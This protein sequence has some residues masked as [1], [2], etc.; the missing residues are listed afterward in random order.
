M[1]LPFLSI[2]FEQIIFM[3][4]LLDFLEPVDLGE[5]NEDNAYTDGQLAKQVT[6]Y[7]GELPSTDTADIVFVGIQE[8]R[9]SGDPD[10]CIG[11]ADAIRKQLYKLHYW[12]DDIKMA[13]IGN[14]RSGASMKDSYAAIKTVL[15]ELYK[16]KKTVVLLGG[17]HD[18]TL[19]QYQA[20]RD[21][22]KIV[23]AT[24]I[25]AMIDLRGE[26][27]LRSESFL[28]E[29]LT[30]EPN[31][32]KHYNHIGFQSYFVHPR[33]LD[34]M[35]KLRFDCYR[36]GRVR[37]EMDQMEPIFRSTDLLSLDINAIRH[38]DAPSNIESPNGLTGEEACTLARYAG[39]SNKLSSFGFYGYQPDL[40]KQEMTAKQIAQMI[41]YFIDGRQVLK[42][43]A[44]IS[45]R[46]Y[47]LEYHTMIADTN[48][49]FLQ[50]KKTKRWWLQ[51]PD[52]RF[53][54]CSH[55]DYLQACNN[56]IPERW[57]KAQEIN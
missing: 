37:E 16:M 56:D 25:D 55:H 48:S 5:V 12:H 13:D 4:D 38:A 45:E 11:A 40:D 28:L 52:G 14:I 29:L 31:F 54:P 32:V 53:I 7:S 20:Y 8:S 23:E 34:T 21:M 36:V 57:L 39:M 43:E 46:E 24:C 19:A 30:E 18:I 17:S 51:L 15:M 47:Y 44:P 41:W 10:G 6:V 26:S 42:N 33:M 9:G 22:D 3:Y 1:Y 27:H 35:D 49:V 50:N 2:M